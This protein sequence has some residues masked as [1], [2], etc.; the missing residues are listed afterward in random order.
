M[1]SHIHTV[2]Q[3]TENRSAA[4]ALYRR[5]RLQQWLG[6]SEQALALARRAVEFADYTKAYSLIARMTLP[7]EDYVQVLERIHRHLRPRGYIEIGVCRG[8]SFAKVLPETAAIG[9]DP[10]PQLERPSPANHKVFAETSDHFF[11][12]H[13]PLA[14]LGNRNVDMAFIDGMH[15]FEFAFRDFVSLERICTR[16]SVILVHDC[17]PLDARTAA[18]ERVTRFWSGDI[19]RLV[20]LLRRHRPDLVIH[21]IGA[22]PTGLGIILNLDPQSCV[23]ASRID[24][25]IEEYLALD[26][27]VLAG[28]Q[29]KMLGLCRND[30]PVIRDLLDR[31]SAD[32]TLGATGSQRPLAAPDPRQNGT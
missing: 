5:A 10:Q 12:H 32:R 27:S 24:E 30:W 19:W 25:L 7:G 8:D 4:R 1:S 14:E 22:A 2:V 31:R 16:E 9:I 20:L 23:L 13:D 15:H 3:A 29:A 17:Y 26:F 21:T 11:A 28:R 18:R 6:R